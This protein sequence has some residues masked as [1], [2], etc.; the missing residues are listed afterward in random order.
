[1]PK[2]RLTEAEMQEGLIANW[3]AQ[4]YREAKANKQSRT[5]LDKACIDAYNG[6]TKVT[7]PSYASNH[8]SNYIHAT[9]ETIRPIM[10]DNNPKFQ[11]L[12]RT[13]EGREK[14]ELVQ[15]ALD[16]EWDR[17]RMS[18]K[19]PQI[20]NTSLIT[21]TG[22]VYLP[23]NDKQKQVTPM[24]INQMNFFPDPMATSMADAEFVIYATYKHINI[25]KKLFPHQAEY[26]TG[27][28]VTDDDLVAQKVTQP[29]S[30]QILILE[31][32][33]RD[34]TTIDPEEDE[35]GDI[36]KGARKYPKG[37]V[38]T[39][40]PVQGIVLNDRKNPY[41]D[42]KFPFVLFKDYDVPFT[43]FGSGDVEQ[44]LSPQ[45]SLNELNNAVIDN[46]KLTANSPWVVDKN[47]GIPH[48]S[49]TNED[50][51]VIR[52]NPGTNLRRMEIPS[53][54]QYIT[55]KILELKGDIETIAGIHN[56]TR[57]EAGDS[58]VA[59]QAIMALQE[60]GQARV[61]LKVRIM[62]QALAEVA[63]MWYSR[64]QQFWKADR[65]IRISDI[66][67]KLTM[68]NITP[69]DLALDF[70]IIITAG[71]TM[72]VNRN[73]MLDLMIR[74]G[75]TQAEDG[76]PMVDREAIM[77]FIPINNKQQILERMN[78]RAEG[79]LQEEAQAMEQQLDQMT[80]MIQSLSQQV[81]KLNDEHEKIKESN[82]EK[83]LVQNGYEKGKSDQGLTDDDIYGIIESE[84]KIPDEILQEIE[85]LSD[86]EIQQLLQVY[87]D[88]ADVI[89][90]NS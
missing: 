64:M 63:T 46:A 67:G 72:P 8:I 49:L 78:K 68:G 16:Y 22:V 74:L 77:E 31:C 4:R 75:Q 80:E 83:E 82:K 9:L 25:V 3:V 90:N 42:G 45:F 35:H 54:P 41:N 17:S 26:L 23:W 79:R 47:C 61:R 87:P 65:I 11:A 12:A 36:K 66:N 43:F 37:R 13:P 84:K 89:A 73:A 69:V 21:G 10:T 52:I 32:W 14:A 57:G 39:V 30:N 34:Y 58:V 6:D 55:N 85:L 48:N 28:G 81:E 18:T 33:C 7:K 60:A 51:L 5:K 15:L 1:M 40:A 29:I 24:V 62:E 20:I 2:E 59:A 44:L 19:L 70:D 88:L 76:L 50:G 27:T 86:E 56:S 71:S 38:I 53:M